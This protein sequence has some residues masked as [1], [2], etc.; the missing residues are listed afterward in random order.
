MSDIGTITEIEP[1]D[2]L[3]WIE[4]AGGDRIRFG[5]T[6]CKGFVPAIGMT[7]E[8]LGTRPGFR[9]VLKATEVRAAAGAAVSSAAM[10]AAAAAANTAAPVAVPRTGLHTFQESGV[11]GDDLLLALLGRADVDDVLHR[12]LIALKFEPKPMFARNLACQNPWLYVL[13]TDGAGNGYGVYAHPLIAE[14]QA[15]P[16]V[17]WN[18]E[19]FALRSLAADTPS[20]LQGKLAS[21]GASGAPRE[22]IARTHQTLVKLGMPDAQG[23]PFGEVPAAPWLPPDDAAL[24]PLDDY[25]KETDGAEMERGLLAYASRRRDARAKEALESLYGTWG[26]KPPG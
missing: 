18:H 15:L 13:A 19:S 12:D 7:V 20:F 16:W 5:G 26:W 4:I 3:G 2:G 17:S 21:A 10:A 24:R 23:Q 22:V 1:E 9:G 25:L 6:A 11:R 8:V 14:Q